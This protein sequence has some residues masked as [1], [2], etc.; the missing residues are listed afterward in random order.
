G[1]LF[2]GSWRLPF[3]SALVFDAFVLAYAWRCLDKPLS[4]WCGA[5]VAGLGIGMLTSLVLVDGLQLLLPA[6]LQLWRV[7]WLAHWLAMAT[8]AVLL[9]RDLRAGV[10]TRALVLLLAFLLVQS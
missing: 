9:L 4:T 7:H 2:V 6:Q 5:A 10:W 8:L 3:F 1:Q